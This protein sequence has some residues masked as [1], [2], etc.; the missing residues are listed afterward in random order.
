MLKLVKLERKYIPQLN[1]MM[2]E[3]TNSNEKII[4]WSIRK[5][6]YHNIDEYIESLEVKEAFD[7]YVPYLTFFCL[8]TDRNIFVGAV[9]IRLYLNDKLAFSDGHIGGW[10]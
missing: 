8:D 3:W 4:P 5:T 7:K 1:E 6:D 2:D 10:N 9:N